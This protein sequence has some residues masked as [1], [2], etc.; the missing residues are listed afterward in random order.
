VGN[1]AGAVTFLWLRKEGEAPWSTVFFAEVGEG[2]SNLWGLGGKSNQQLNYSL[3]RGL[4][5]I[6]ELF[7]AIHPIK[8]LSNTFKSS[9]IFY[10][11][12]Q[13]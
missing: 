9:L 10:R 11:S 5:G 2:G 6:L 12:L 13:K 3:M 4:R 7:C 1:E 8:K